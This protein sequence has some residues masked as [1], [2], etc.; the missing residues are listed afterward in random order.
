MAKAIFPGATR[1]TMIGV[2]LAGTI[3]DLDLLSARFS[4]AA[5][6]EMGHTYGHSLV[7]AV[8][9]SVIAGS[10]CA[11]L[12][13]RRKATGMRTATIFV[14]MFCAAA[15]H[16]LLDICQ[17]D[18]AALLWPFSTRRFSADWVA[19]PDIWILLI[20]LAGLLLPKLLGLITEEIG[21]KSKAG[22]GRREAAAALLVV[23]LYICLRIMLHADAVAALGSR[24]YGADLPRTTAALPVSQSP[25]RWLGLAET[26]SAWHL[27]DVAIV[28]GANPKITGDHTFYKPEDSAALNTARNTQT[29]LRF[30][31]N[32]RFPR[33][34]VEK[35]ETGAT[36]VTFRE[37]CVEPYSSGSLVMAI[38]DIDP[39]GSILR[40]QLAW[41]PAT[42]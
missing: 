39:S 30:L 5:F 27:F 22:R 32:V 4:P 21:V 8:A 37:A 12:A 23:A 16:L 17:S 36:R 35:T 33:A 42:K 25:F 40:E 38:V 2:L 29:A 1:T 9:I 3:A 15:L 13:K 6:L 18:G 41:D 10:A 20:L 34:A 11:F 28:P 31:R 19:Q 24:S 26:E 7:S 14:V